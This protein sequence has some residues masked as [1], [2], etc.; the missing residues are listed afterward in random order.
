MEEADGSQDI[1]ENYDLLDAGY[2]SVPG[3]KAQGSRHRLE[4]RGLRQKPFI[5]FH[6]P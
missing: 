3:S 6:L 1:G 4:D 2:Q 5:S